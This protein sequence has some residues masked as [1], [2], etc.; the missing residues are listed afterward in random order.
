MPS[1]HSGCAA[2]TAAGRQAIFFVDTT[3]VNNDQLNSIAVATTV[4]NY[5]ALYSDAHADGCQVIMLLAPG[6]N[7]G[8]GLTINQ[9]IRNGT[10]ASDSWIDLAKVLPDISDSIF[11]D[12]VSHPTVIGHHLLAANLIRAMMAGGDATNGDLGVYSVPVVVSSP[13]NSNR[14]TLGTDGSVTSKSLVLNGNPISNTPLMTFTSY[15]N[16]ALNNAYCSEGPQWTPTNP[17]T[18]TKFQVFVSTAPAGCT[19]NGTIVVQQGG[20]ATI[21]STVTFVNGTQNYTNSGL[22]IAVN[23]GFIQ[24]NVG[25]TAMAG[26]TTVPSGAYFLIE[27][28]MQ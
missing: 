27:Y 2:A 13:A 24:F 12:A 15:Q 6:Q 22:S 16:C 19:T 20:F 5:N 17:I 7:F 4:S 1:G 10:I 28:K 14:V 9:D 3:T 11:W 23:S 26:C 21:L 25:S 8:A 18:I